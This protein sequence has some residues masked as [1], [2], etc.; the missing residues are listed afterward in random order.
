MI[1]E[2]RKKKI[3]HFFNVLD[4]NHNGILQPN[5]FKDVAIKICEYAGIDKFNKKY[6]NTIV[7]SYRI[8]IQV[9]TDLEKHIELEISK[10]EWVLFI[11]KNLI[12]DLDAS[13]P[14]DHYITRIVF[15]IFNLFDINNDAVISIDEYVRMFKIYEIDPSFSQHA[16]EQLDRNGDKVISREEFAD[17]VKEYFLSDDAGARGNWIFGPW[18]NDK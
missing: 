15:Y 8:F 3:H 18:D 11:E 10:E 1:T 12:S 9:L 14:I 2:I 4:T 16:F 17:A 5:D 7:Q 13:P 6:D